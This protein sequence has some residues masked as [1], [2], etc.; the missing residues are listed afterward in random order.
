VTASLPGHFDNTDKA[1]NVAQ[2]SGI[3]LSDSVN[4]EVISATGKETVV[5]EAAK[6]KK[7]LRKEPFFRHVDLF[8]IKRERSRCEPALA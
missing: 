7:R 1:W 6:V 2:V 8:A 5:R 4:N 3:T